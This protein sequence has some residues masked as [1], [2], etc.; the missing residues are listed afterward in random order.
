MKPSK[1]GYTDEITQPAEEVYC[2]CYYE[3]IYNLDALPAVMLTK[4][5][6]AALAA[7]DEV[8]LAAAAE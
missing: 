7:L 2:R 4:K 5:G 3:Y 8:E 6:Q 1:A